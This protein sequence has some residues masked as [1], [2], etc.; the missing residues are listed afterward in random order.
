M[1]KKEECKIH[2]P[3]SQRLH[4]FSACKSDHSQS[5]SCCVSQSYMSH[6]YLVHV[7]RHFLSWTLLSSAAFFSASLKTFLGPMVQQ[8]AIL[9]DP[10]YFTLDI[11][12]TRLPHYD[13]DVLK[14]WVLSQPDTI[15]QV[16]RALRRE[17]VRCEASPAFGHA[18]A[19]FSVFIERIRNQFLKS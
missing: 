19:N 14:T 7:G 18:N 4:I 13:V 6:G 5:F 3:S 11:K 9:C 10:G 15:E 2:Q 1:Y 8:S 16:S 12:S 17:A